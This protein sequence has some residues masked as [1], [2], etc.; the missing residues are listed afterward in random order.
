MRVLIIGGTRF[1]GRHIAEL[2]LQRGHHLTLLH[3][4]RSGPDLF[5]EAEHRIADRD[6]ELA[7]LATGE[8]DSVIDTSAYV[9]RQVRAL[10]AV[11]SGRVGQYQLISSISAYARFE[12]DGTDENAALATL[13]DTTVETV[14]GDT[15]GGLKALCEHA[16]L[17][18]FGPRCLIARPGLI[19]G[20]FDPTGRFTWWPTRIARG[21]E[22]LAPGDPQARVQFIDARDGAAWL[23]D[24]AEAQRSGC[25]NLTGPNTALTMA[26]L[27]STAQRV[28][29][30]S[31]Q[32]TW[33]D[34]AFLLAQ[35][36]APWSELPVWLPKE[37][38]AL[39][40]V[41]TKRTIE[42]GLVC[43]PLAQTLTDTAEW[44]R[45]TA[46]PLPAG[47]GLS[48]ERE[49]ALLQAWAARG[50]SGSAASATSSGPAA[51]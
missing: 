39:H 29:C 8:W 24:Q 42:T 14:T 35:G 10:A 34:E 47:V 6:A 32:L 50:V 28:L 37:S 43:R 20:P 12:P 4:G 7:V 27:L 41:K 21:G 51:A 31:A 3:R 36:V 25:F 2:A 13:P 18:A 1:L 33:V 5:P 17:A 15:Y 44:A 9:P 45:S 30:P 23:L 11:L 40:A 26:E 48:A 49:A 22:V 46:T 38:A 19:V 16:A